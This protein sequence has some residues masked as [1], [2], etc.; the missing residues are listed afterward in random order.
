MINPNI[1]NYPSLPPQKV[2]YQSDYDVLEDICRPQNV[3]SI[4]SKSI[5]QTS[6]PNEVKIVTNSEIAGC[7]FYKDLLPRIRIKAKEIITDF[8]TDEIME[9]TNTALET[10]WNMNN[11]SIGWNWTLRDYEI[12]LDG[13]TA[14][15]RLPNDFHGLNGVSFTDTKDGKLPSKGYFGV[16][17]PHQWDSVQFGNYVMYKH[18]YDG[19]YMYVRTKDMNCWCDCG[20]KLRGSIFV[21][22]YMSAPVVR[23]L[24]DRIC[25]LPKQWGAESILLDMIVKEMFAT[26]G[27]QYPQSANLEIM[28]NKLM[29]LDRGEPLR[30]NLHKNQ[31]IRF[32]IIR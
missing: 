13:D 1:C 6:K 4:F 30:D 17:E 32:K 2:N 3:V 24:E 25:G 7:I 5:E 14:K 10:L 29:K 18:E 26:K 31:A 12:V 19:F 8:N 16:V 20:L 9:S 11:G 15:Y 21:K 23:S 22:Y 27:R 28:L